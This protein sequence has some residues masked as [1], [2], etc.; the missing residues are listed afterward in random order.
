MGITTKHASRTNPV[1]QKETLLLLLLH[2]NSSNKIVYTIV[3]VLDV[4][5]TV[6]TADN[7]ISGG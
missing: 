1:A 6:I 5:L 3:L 7:Q 4:G 2:E